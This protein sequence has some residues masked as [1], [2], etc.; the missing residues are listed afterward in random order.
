MPESKLD[1]L[2]LIAKLDPLHIFELTTAFPNQCAEAIRIG[3]AFDC[4]QVRGDF[5]S[6]LLAGMGGSAA[7]G[8]FLQAVFREDGKVPFF[9][10]RDYRLPAWISPSTLV[11][12][13]SYSGNTEET[14]SCFEHARSLGA[15]FLA[16]SSG[17]KLEEA[18]RA[19]SVPH[20]GIPRGQ[21]PRTAL[22]YLFLPLLVVSERLGLVPKQ[23]VAGLDS[24]LKELSGEWGIGLRDEENP[25]KQLAF[26]LFDTTP[27]VY[28]LGLW[29]STVA[30]RWKAQLNE[31]SKMMAFW[32][33]YPEWNH[34]ELMA[35]TR[36]EGPWSAVILESGDESP[37]MRS[38]LE[39]TL[40]EVGRERCFVV[41][42]RGATLLEKMLSLSY[43]G[44]WVS[45]YLAVLNEVDPG[46]IAVMDR[47]KTYLARH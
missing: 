39:Y 25:A 10:C 8:D 42:S 47:L 11:I 30:S 45:L 34:N 23:P 38:R 28:G 37:S 35:W 21:P 6:V 27:L 18:A 12:C 5:R 17:G 4:S 15:S 9:V 43:F 40:D 33:A 31:N 7:G 16:L 36:A 29:Q 22:G 1:D 32:N 26:K 20:I 24:F 3:E 14:L 46:D 2:D 13:S 41:G 19:A 44:D